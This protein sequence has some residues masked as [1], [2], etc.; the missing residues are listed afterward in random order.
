L[1]NFE[2]FLKLSLKSIGPEN[3]V[4]LVG[5]RETFPF[6][7]HLK[8][9]EAYFIGGYILRNTVTEK[10]SALKG[11][12][13]D[14]F[15]YSIFRELTRRIYEKIK[16]R[17]T[18]ADTLD[19][20]LVNDDID[21]GCETLK[22]LL[23]QTYGQYTIALVTDLVDLTDINSVRI[24]NVQLNKI[25]E[26]F[27]KGLPETFGVPRSS[28]LA[29]LMKA[30]MTRETFLEENKNFVALSKETS[31]YHHLGEKSVVFENALTE[32]KQ[33][34]AYL[35]CAKHFF[36]NVKGK[37]FEFKSRRIVLGPVGS[38]YGEGVSGVQKYFVRK[39]NDNWVRW[40]D[41]LGSQIKLSREAFILDSQTCQKLDEDFF[42]KQYNDLMSNI[43]G[44]QIAGKV[45]RSF[46]WFLKGILEDDLTDQVV[47]LF[48][49]LE[50]LLSSGQ[51]PFRGTTDDLA[52][53][54][55]IMLT[56]DG[57][58]RYAYKKAIKR[59]YALRCKIVHGGETISDKDFP[60]IRQLGNYTVWSLRGILSRVQQILNYGK[61]ERHLQEYFDREK[62]RGGFSK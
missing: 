29:A 7:D 10:E 50:A 27:V 25:D 33:V 18:I 38:V 49:S 3:K 61:K 20:Y 53:N 16:E 48:I 6:E 22:K 54:V 62:L 26:N 36:E 39:K 45:R 12:T 17:V 42:L 59:A 43:Q 8:M 46:D 15:A 30:D 35:A 58:E 44:N 19:K 57:D 5:R 32:F 14:D 21:F 34:F 4:E 11:K 52:E 60:I 13:N 40:I 55:A 1:K 28:L 56:P 23:R 41:T 24:G 47:A 2:I 31:G 9:S 37:K 51:D